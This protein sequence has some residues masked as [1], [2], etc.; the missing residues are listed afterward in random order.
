MFMQKWLDA[1]HDSGFATN[2][3]LIANLVWQVSA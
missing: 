1:T 2:L 3:D